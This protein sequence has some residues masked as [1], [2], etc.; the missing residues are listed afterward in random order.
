MKHRFEYYYQPYSMFSP[1]PPEHRI[2]VDTEANTVGELLDIFQ[3]YLKACGFIFGPEEYLMR[4]DP[5]A[6][7]EQV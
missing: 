2:R 6:E 4:Y 5:E 1:E 7:G 3:N